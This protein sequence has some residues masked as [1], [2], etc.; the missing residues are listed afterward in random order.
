MI[1]RKTFHMVRRYTT[2]FELCKSTGMLQS[3]KMAY[4]DLVRAT[5][6]SVPT[7][8]EFEYRE[9][10]LPPFEKFYV[11]EPRVEPVRR[12]LPSSSM[13]A[14]DGV[15]QQVSDPSYRQP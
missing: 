9:P 14:F 15:K 5:A 13:P 3:V 8:P 10:P 7:I 2:T 12:L 11:E 6:T 1:V 4:Q